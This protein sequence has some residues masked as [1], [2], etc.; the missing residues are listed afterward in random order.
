MSLDRLRQVSE[1]ATPGPW[2]WERRNGVSTATVWSRGKGLV[3]SVA[4]MGRRDVRPEVREEHAANAEFIATFDPPT[5]K[6]LL[7]VAEAAD[8]IQSPA[9]EDDIA[10]YADGVRRTDVVRLTKALDRL[11][12]V[13]S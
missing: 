12:E 1:A 11:R 2:W 8:V 7:D 3:N 10:P 5:V 13:S 6:A 4:R 9:Y